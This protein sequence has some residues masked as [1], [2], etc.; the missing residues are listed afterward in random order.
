MQYGKSDTSR[1]QGG[2]RNG[3][4]YFALYAI[5]VPANNEA[6][7]TGKD[8]ENATAE[9][10]KTN[11][12]VNIMLTMTEN[13]SQKWEKMTRNNVGKSIA[14]VVDRKVVSCPV[15]YEAISGGI[16]NINGVFSIQEGKLLAARINAGR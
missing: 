3:S 8:I 4:N 12:T 13:G 16:T 11:G 9:A 10:D 6:M 15:V 14:I 2:F 7:I 1:K 5:K